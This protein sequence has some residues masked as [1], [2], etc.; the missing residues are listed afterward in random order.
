MKDRNWAGWVG[1]RVL[2]VA[3]VVLVVVTG[4]LARGG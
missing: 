3:W 4:M 1:L 2:G